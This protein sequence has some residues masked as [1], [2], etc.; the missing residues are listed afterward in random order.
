MVVEYGK[1]YHELYA[2]LSIEHAF[3]CY[4]FD[5]VK[6]ESPDWQSALGN[7]GLEVTCAADPH[8]GYFRNFAYQYLGKEI[9]DIP[10]KAAEG[11]WGEQYLNDERLFCI[12]ER[13]GSVSGTRHIDL[14]I[15]MADSKLHKLNHN[16]YIF[17]K[18]DLYLF[19]IY[20]IIDAD[21]DMFLEGY[22]QVEKNYHRTF[23]RI[24]LFDG[25]VLYSIMMKSKAI[26]RCEFTESSLCDLKLNTKSLLHINEWKNG[27][28]FHETMSL[29]NV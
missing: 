2:M 10:Q 19:T 6:S 27:T 20:G 12:T 4:S 17:T 7:T 5:M 8:Y 24:F 28:S 16:F 11:F 25:I 15:R 1:L 23:D 21:I 22:T 3:P 9:I 14:A 26:E 13:R 29:I 18:N